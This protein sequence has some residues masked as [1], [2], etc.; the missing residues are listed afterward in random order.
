MNAAVP[1][2]I[3]AI[4]SSNASAAK[5]RV[6]GLYRQTLKSLPAVIAQYNL[7]VP[8][9][10]V[11]D[12]VAHEFRRNADLQDLHMIDIAIFRGE[13]ELDEAI[14]L[15]K[16]P[17]HIWRYVDPE[18]FKGKSERVRPNPVLS[19]ITVIISLIHFQA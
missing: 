14:K 17:T 18:G 12:R 13:Q 16:T 10:E 6:I 15:F 7:P 4:K 1:A 5:G 11:R 8:Y 3:N 9:N 19:Y 2:T